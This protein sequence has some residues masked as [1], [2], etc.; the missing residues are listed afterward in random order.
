MKRIWALFLLVYLIF[1]LAVLSA[2]A[3]GDLKPYPLKHFVYLMGE[4]EVV[5]CADTQTGDIWPTYWCVS[6]DDDLRMTSNY[7]E[8]I[9]YSY[10]PNQATNTPLVGDIMAEWGAPTWFHDGDLTWITA[11]WPGKGV[12][13]TAPLRRFTPFSEIVGIWYERESEKAWYW[14]DWRGFR[15]TP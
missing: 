11:A 2:L 8:V 12:Y 13:V 15:R 6:K 9:R 14:N 10:Y 5:Y 4:G 7:K 3:F 1:V